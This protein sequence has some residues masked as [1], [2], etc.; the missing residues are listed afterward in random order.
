MVYKGLAVLPA[1][2]AADGCS[3]PNSLR[4]DMDNVDSMAVCRYAHFR[5][6]CFSMQDRRVDIQAILEEI[7]TEVTPLFGNGKV[8]DYIPALGR[9]DG[10]QFGMA[11]RMADGSEYS[12]GDAD[13]PFSIQS[14][15]KLFTL[16]QAIDIEGEEVWQ[17]I[18]REPSGTAFNSL[19]QLEYEQGIPRNPFINAGALVVTDIIT[20]HSSDANRRISDFVRLLAGN[21][22]LA[23]D[24]EVALSER[25]HGFRNAALANLMASFGNIKCDIEQLLGAYFHQ[26]SLSVT[27]ADLARAVLPLV[28]QGYSPIL[29]RSVLTARDSKRINAL[30]LTC[31]MYDAVGRFAYSVGLPAKSG[32]GGG[33][34]AVLPGEFSVCVWSP[35]LDPSGNSLIGSKALELFTTKTGLSVF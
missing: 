3:L 32:V 35:E 14:I 24:D 25:K 1:P 34:V 31:G 5:K 8:A 9:V 21:P 4:P 6:V 7:E 27:C 13:T 11:V 17:R 33:I 28:H 22:D 29:D 19:V 15:S 16:M 12:V 23:V 26:C 30:M 18:G 10:R 2:R 20:S